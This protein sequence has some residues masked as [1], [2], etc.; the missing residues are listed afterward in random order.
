MPF[1][2]V[3][4]DVVGEVGLVPC[5][6]GGTAIEEWARGSFLYENMVKRAKKAVESGDG[7]IRAMLW[8]QGE[9]DT[10]SKKCVDAYRG[11]MEK[12]ID[13]VR[14]DL[15]LPHLPIIQVAIASGDDKYL[16]KIREIQKAIDV[17]NVVCVDAK[18]LELKEDHLHL[19]TEA[20]VELGQMLAH[21]YLTHFQS[22]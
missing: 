5:A 2:N 3:V 4:K 1:A 19:T 7:R 9:S 11:K 8:Y 6:V 15:G 17:E 18:G 10:L 21:A 13:N 12:F 14:Q 16:E 20:C 22:K